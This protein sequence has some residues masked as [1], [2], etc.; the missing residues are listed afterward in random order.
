MAHEASEAELK[1]AAEEVR[2]IRK[3]AR[4]AARRDFNDPTW[5]IIDAGE[6]VHVR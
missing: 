1:E 6:P 2:E 3:P 5:R 4:P